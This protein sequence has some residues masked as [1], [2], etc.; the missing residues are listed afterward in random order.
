MGATEVGVVRGRVPVAM[1]KESKSLG[2]I[3][4]MKYPRWKI[5]KEGW[6]EN[7][8]KGTEVKGEVVF[9]T[10]GAGGNQDSR[11]VGDEGKGLDVVVI[12]TRLRNTR[13]YE[14]TPYMRHG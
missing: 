1:G 8:T 13:T 6:N 11:L 3:I 12:A 14:V 9:K 4:L 2:T 7:R 5:V 10:N